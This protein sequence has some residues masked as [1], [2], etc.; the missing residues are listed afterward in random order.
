MQQPSSY[1]GVLFVRVDPNLVDGDAK[2][3][4]KHRV[5]GLVDGSPKFFGRSLDE[6]HDLLSQFPQPRRPKGGGGVFLRSCAVRR[7][8]AVAAVCAVGAVAA[9]GA[10]TARSE[11]A[12][13]LIL[14]LLLAL[15]HVA[16]G[17]LGVLDSLAGEQILHDQNPDLG[18]RGAG[19]YVVLHAAEVLNWK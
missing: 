16:D 8:S 1:P 17:Q 9:V 4:G 15:L 19:G 2:V 3:V 10:V 18:G 5:S 6:I 14:R 11:Q 13:L 7:L 12:G